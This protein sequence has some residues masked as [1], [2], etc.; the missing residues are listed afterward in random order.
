MERSGEWSKADVAVKAA[1]VAMRRAAERS[2]NK[3]T[4]KDKK[5]DRL[6][7]ADNM[8]VLDFC[9][10]L[11]TLGKQRERRR[12]GAAKIVQSMRATTTYPRGEMRLHRSGEKLVHNDFLPS[13]YFHE[14]GDEEV[15]EMD[16]GYDGEKWRSRAPALWQGAEEGTLTLPHVDYWFE[17]KD[18]TMGTRIGVREGEEVIIAWHVGKEG[19]DFEDEDGWFEGLVGRCSLA[20]IHAKSGD[21]VEIEEGAW[22]MVVTVKAKVHLAWHV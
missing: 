20:I 16:E 10:M 13:L 12:P 6:R 21:V 14:T 19:G 4:L 1:A 5:D 7:R 3:E 18:K 22:H 17:K 2:M 11:E 15:W 8:K 9:R